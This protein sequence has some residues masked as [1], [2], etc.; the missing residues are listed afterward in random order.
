MMT[1]ANRVDSTDGEQFLRACGTDQPLRMAVSRSGEVSRENWVFT[2]PYLIVGRRADADLVL[3]HWQI[4]RRH[5]YIQ[6]LDGGYICVDLGSRTGTFGGPSTERAGWIPR[7]KAIQVGPYEVRPIWPERQVNRE[8][9]NLPGLVWELPES[10]RNHPTWRMD[11]S[12]VLIGHSPICRI[13]ILARDVSAFHASLVRTR[14]GVWVVDL[15]GLGGVRVNGHLVRF[16]RLEDGDEVQ[17][18]GH[19]LRPRYDSPPPRLATLAD[20][21]HPPVIVEGQ[22]ADLDPWAD[23][24]PARIGGFPGHVVAVP[25]GHRIPAPTLPPMTIDLSGVPGVAGTPMEPV[26]T[27]LAQQFGAIQQQMFDQ[28]HQTMMA[29]FEGFATLHREQSEAMRE[30][31]EHVRRLSQEIEELQ[32]ET[33]RLIE[34]SRARDEAAAKAA[35]AAAAARL[36]N[37]L[38]GLVPPPNT[39]PPAMARPAGP[40]T[41]TG[42]GTGDIHALLV[43]RLATMHN[44]RQGRWQ[45]ILSMMGTKS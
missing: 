19:I 31:M 36:A 40:A 43:R 15:L 42:D 23:Q 25:G 37:P 22:G 32:R 21:D 27:A 38:P 28:F 41:P 44:E 5:A 7:D 29:M 8:P 16:A 39:I 9:G 4:S 14:M 34:A 3:D 13:R 30:E 2:Q 6:F 12:L 10:A 18:G 1:E 33:E 45:K 17:V 26:V 24:L 35:A 20:P 11:R